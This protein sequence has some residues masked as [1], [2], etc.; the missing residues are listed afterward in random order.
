[1]SVCRQPMQNGTNQFLASNEV[2]S[3]TA[4]RNQMP[5]PESSSLCALISSAAYP[6]G[7]SC[8]LQSCN[9]AAISEP[10]NARN[11]VSQMDVTDRFNKHVVMPLPAI[12][13]VA[14]L[15]LPAS[16]TG[17]SGPLLPDSGLVSSLTGQHSSLI[18]T[19]IY[20]I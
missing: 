11:I 3:S 7:G 9:D 14:G 5:Q 18:C 15:Q 1:M 17:Q 2:V 16:Q 10:V 20:I 13:S 6:A 19:V 4:D 8:M 12:H